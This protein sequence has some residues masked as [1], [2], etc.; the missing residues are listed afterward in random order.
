MTTEERELEKQKSE[1]T[2]TPRFYTKHN[3]RSRKS[4]E[5]FKTTNNL[6]IVYMKY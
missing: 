5:N 1:L 3:D 2:F 6:K 4:V